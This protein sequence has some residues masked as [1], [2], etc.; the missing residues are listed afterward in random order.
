MSANVALELAVEKASSA[1]G[2]GLQIFKRILL[3]NHNT[4]NKPMMIRIKS[5][6]K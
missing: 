3:F 2:D 6:G 4:L 1:R 5:T